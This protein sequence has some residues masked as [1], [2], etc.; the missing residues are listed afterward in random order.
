MQGHNFDL[1]LVA[2]YG[3]HLGP[4]KFKPG[5][6]LNRIDE[7]REEVN[8][9]ASRELWQIPSC[10]STRSLCDSPCIGINMVF[11][12]SSKSHLYNASSISR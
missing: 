4:K 5:F 7:I 10:F 9:L 12:F 8:V 1:V 6:R 11:N 2:P 3:Q